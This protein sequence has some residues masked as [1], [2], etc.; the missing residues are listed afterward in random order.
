MS[1]RKRI[2]SILLSWLLALPQC[3]A[4]SKVGVGFDNAEA[5]QAA[6]ILGIRPQLDRWLAMQKE[7][8]FD[9]QSE[10]AMLLKSLVLRKILRG[11][12]EV[13]QSC[14]KIDLEH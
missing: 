10:E 3:L 5:K 2:F 9:N 6:D 14:N 7:G 12:L 8:T 11:V 13:R 4:L 1:L